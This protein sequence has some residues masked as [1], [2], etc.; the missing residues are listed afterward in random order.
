ML[1]TAYG[2]WPRRM[3]N[4][5]KMYM[6][7]VTVWVSTCFL[8]RLILIRIYRILGKSLASI[9]N[10]AFD[11]GFKVHHLMPWNTIDACKSNKSNMTLSPISYYQKH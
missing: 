7:I 10:I 2:S 9:L 1:W 6:F 4:G 3:G 8:A 5:T 11:I